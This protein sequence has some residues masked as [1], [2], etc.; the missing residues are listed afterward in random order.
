MRTGDSHALVYYTRGMF[1][2]SFT[3]LPLYQ[4]FIISDEGGDRFFPLCIN[5]LQSTS[6]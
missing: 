3:E 4:N 1:I 2:W 5:H 6:L